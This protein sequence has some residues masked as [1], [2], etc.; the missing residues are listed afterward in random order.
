MSFVQYSR[1]IT[2]WL[3]LFLRPAQTKS[4]RELIEYLMQT[5]P[6]DM[7]AR[8]RLLG[9][10]KNAVKSKTQ[11][12]MLEAVKE[13][14]RLRARDN[15]EILQNCDNLEKPLPMQP[16]L[17]TPGLVKGAP[18]E[19]EPVPEPPPDGEDVQEIEVIIAQGTD[20]EAEDSDEEEPR[21]ED[22]SQSSDAAKESSRPN[23][24]AENSAPIATVTKPTARVLPPWK[25]TPP[26]A[27][28]KATAVPS[29]APKA[30][31][32]P[33]A[34]PKAT[35]VPSAATKATAV[36]SAATKA[37]AVPSAA[38][39]ATAAVPFPKGSQ[40]STYMIGGRQVKIVAPLTAGVVEAPILSGLTGRQP[41]ERMALQPAMTPSPP[42][43]R[44]AGITEETEVQRSRPCQVMPVG[45]VTMEATEEESED[46]APQPKWQ[47]LVDR[48]SSCILGAVEKP[49]AEAPVLREDLVPETPKLRS[50]KSLSLSEEERIQMALAD[51]YLGV[52]ACISASK[53]ELQAVGRRSCG[54]CWSGFV[55]EVQLTAWLNRWHCSG[56]R[57][58]RELRRSCSRT[59]PCCP[60][61]GP[62]SRSD[63]LCTTLVAPAIRA[64]LR[65]GLRLLG[66]SVPSTKIHQSIRT[67]F[68]THIET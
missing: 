30:T 53:S 37:S 65:M 26:S 61:W 6:R 67:E 17:L 7:L 42:P 64:V 22:V 14:W 57:L 62:N 28:P 15:V 63:S 56:G 8:L 27:A 12:E 13:V 55:Q 19:A 48:L 24:A 39:K 3:C 31:A 5:A 11:A 10:V 4:K 59:S 16:G 40:P 1:L 44:L 45:R 38:T 49:R 9:T 46:E 60:P 68:H 23:S 32:V 20:N 33:S 51:L 54:R 41:R 50:L 35:A 34:A 43:P 25:Q 29:A 18:A 36:P 47:A 58:R 52:P 66:G 21:E 2:C